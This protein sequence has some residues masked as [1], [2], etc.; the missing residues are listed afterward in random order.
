M[1]TWAHGRLGLLAWG[2][3]G[4]FAASSPMHQD[5]LDLLRAFIH[6]NVR[7]LI[8]DPVMVPGTRSSF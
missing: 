6:G 4:D 8:V 2:P 7:Y 1:G 3:S 5:F